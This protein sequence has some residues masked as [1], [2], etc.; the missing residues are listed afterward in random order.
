MIPKRFSTTKSL[1]L[2]NMRAYR[3]V[4]YLQ[5]P[6]LSYK[7]QLSTTHPLLK[8]PYLKSLL[9]NLFYDYPDDIY[10]SWTKNEHRLQYISIRIINRV[11]KLFYPRVQQ[12]KYTSLMA[13]LAF[14]FVRK[15][16]WC[17]E[18]PFHL[19]KLSKHEV[20]PRLYT[21]FLIKF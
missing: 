9:L 2:R 3:R 8:P 10:R 16:Y 13:K 6:M 18:G 14:S 17:H 1:I 21:L 19:Y 11:S 20:T 7:G 12:N 5:G 15:G 4:S